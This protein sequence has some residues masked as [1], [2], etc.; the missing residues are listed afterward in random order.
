MR[1]PW[2]KAGTEPALSEVFADPIVQSLMKAD[3]I[4]LADVIRAGSVIVTKPPP[5]EERMRAR[6]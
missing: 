3:R 1:Q 6:G 2:S 5:A 4:S